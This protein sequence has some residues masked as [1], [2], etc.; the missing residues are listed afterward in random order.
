[1][2]LKNIFNNLI[3][4][5]ASRGVGA[6]VA[7]HL[8]SRT[9]RLITVSRSASNFGEWVKADISTKQGI[10]IVSNAVGDR[11]LDGLLYMGGTWEDKAFTQ[12][13]SFEKCSD[14]DIENVLMVNLL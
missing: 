9:N 13:Y 3:V 14:E 2:K 6:A 5:G 4:V 1:M 10:E 12:D 7:E 11:V 8:V